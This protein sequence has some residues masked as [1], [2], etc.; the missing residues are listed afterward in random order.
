[1][2]GAQGQ[3]DGRGGGQ[4]RV[5]AQEDEGERVVL[6]PG[7]LAG[8]GLAGR[9]LQA[10]GRLLAAAAGGL[11]A[12]VVGPAALGGL[13]QPAVRVVRYAVARP[14]AGRG[15]QGL[16]HGV[17]R[18]GEISGAA[19]E[20]AENLRRE[21]AQQVL[22]LRGQLRHRARAPRSGPVPVRT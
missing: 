13:E 15:E 20:H 5:A 1:A 21:G 10:G 7:G 3:R 17:L 11:A 22:G 4:G 9:G 2:D 14:V 19:G 6:V 16:L 8:G 18:G 12:D